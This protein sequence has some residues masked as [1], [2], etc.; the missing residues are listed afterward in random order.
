MMTPGMEQNIEVCQQKIWNCYSRN[1]GVFIPLK[2]ESDLVGFS[3]FSSNF[4]RLPIRRAPSQAIMNCTVSQDCHTESFEFFLR[5]G[6]GHR[7]GLRLR[8]R[9]LLLLRGSAS[10]KGPLRLD[11]ITIG[12]NVDRTFHPITSGAQLF[13]VPALQVFRRFL[14]ICFNLVI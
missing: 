4:H 8:L 3:T 7:G 6:G 9:V 1:I 5:P 12:W 14:K 2:F 11:Y 10:R 13:K